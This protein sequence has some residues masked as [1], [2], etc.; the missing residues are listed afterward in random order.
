ME[1]EQILAERRDDVVVLTLNRPDR[2]N[3]WTPRMSAELVDAISKA[4]DDNDVGAVVVTG[5]GR[6]FCAGADI[7]GQFAAKLDGEAANDAPSPE[8][9]RVDW[10]QF[11][12][13]SKPLVAAINGPCIGVGLTMVLPFDQLVAAEGAKLSARFVKMGLV[14]ELASSHFLVARCGWGAASWLALSGTTILADEALRLRLVDRVVPVEQ[15]LDEALAV[16][17][18]LAANPAPQLRMIK[19]LL[20]ANATETDLNLVQKR[21]MEALNTAYR[22]PEHREA[23]SAFLEKRPPKFR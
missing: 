12:R 5:A 8:T 22:T 9:L 19:E 2:L 23:V 17:S 10:V 11:C 1:Y 20:S 15:V 7:G 16:A 18:E 3:A 6:G 4:N 21:E 13:D 14:P